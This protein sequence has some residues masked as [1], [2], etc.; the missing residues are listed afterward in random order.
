[1]NRCCL[2]LLLIAAAALLACAA[3]SDTTDA[4]AP[5]PATGTPGNAR[6]TA[7]PQPSFY[8][9][10]TRTRI[11]SIDKALDA[12]ERGDAQ[13]L[14]AMIEY[15]PVACTPPGGLGD[16]ACTGGR[17]AGS[18]VNVIGFNQCGNNYEPEDSNPGLQI[19]Q[20]FL[21]PPAG[22]SSFDA[23]LYA[24][25]KRP[26]FGTP[27][28]IPGAFLVVF[29]AGQTLYL[30]YTGVTYFEYVCQPPHVGQE[31]LR[32]VSLVPGPADYFLPPR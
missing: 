23:R 30:D 25:V 10:G 32:V 26:L 16:V 3:P 9:L 13:A 24:I 27:P 18:P 15:Y 2:A 21:T 11:A 20:G 7:T 19:A 14:A 12:V 28:E 31:V 5:L 8:P 17:P 4:T 6:P 22:S 1:M 29:A